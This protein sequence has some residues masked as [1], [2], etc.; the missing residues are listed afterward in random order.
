LTEA[1][2][3]LEGFPLRCP[4][5]RAISSRKSKPFFRV[6]PPK[7]ALDRHPIYARFSCKSCPHPQRQEQTQTN[8]CSQR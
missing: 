1:S 7:R 5:C 8:L 4:F 3:P 6:T 2:L